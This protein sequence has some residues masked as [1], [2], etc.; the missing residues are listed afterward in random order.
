MDRNNE[1]QLAR[2]YLNALEHMTNSN[3]DWRKVLDA[4]SRLCGTNEEMRH[5]AYQYMDML[6]EI[7]K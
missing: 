5:R 7:V 1:V 6:E 3:D 2:I 4:F